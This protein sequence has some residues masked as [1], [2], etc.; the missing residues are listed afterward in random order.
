[1]DHQIIRELLRNCSAASEVL[2]VDADL[3]EE[4]QK[5]IKRIAPNLI[6]KHGQLQEWLVDI[7]DPNNKHRHVSHLYGLFPGEDISPHLNPELD[8]AAAKSLE[9]RGDKGTGWSM[10][11]KINWWARLEDGD[12]AYRCLPT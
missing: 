9:F 1:M 2:G 5:M 12:R 4:W 3:R 8:Q 11:W 7:D 10:A 6:G